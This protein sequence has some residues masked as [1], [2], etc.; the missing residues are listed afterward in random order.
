MSHPDPPQ[1]PSGPWHPR[2]WVSLVR[3]G[4]ECGFER[5]APSL[6]GG[7]AVWKSKLWRVEVEPLR[8]VAE[9]RIHRRAEDMR[10]ECWD[11][12]AS[13]FVCDVGELFGSLLALGVLP[14][15]IGEAA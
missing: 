9:V 2:E 7:A 11:L 5:V 4:R 10:V 12:R 6:T 14:S 15:P 1:V 13:I 8:S 3:Y